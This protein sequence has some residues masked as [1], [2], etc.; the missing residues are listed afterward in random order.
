ML[1][2]TALS[3]L[4]L[5]ALAGPASAGIWTEVPSNTTEDITAIEY[6][7]ADR[8]W[9]TTGGGKIFRRVGGTFQQEAAD[10][11][12]VFRDI[13]F[14]PG[15]NIGLAVGTN[16]RVWRSTDAGDTW[17]VVAVPAGGRQTEERCDLADEA[18]G[19]VDSVRFDGLGNAWI[20]GNALALV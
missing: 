2:V 11:T 5:G 16:G 12:T 9:F 3:V 15:G 6:Q 19:D 4:G 17:N 18:L 10:L 7:S 20:M 14:Q 8:F 1:I 13:E